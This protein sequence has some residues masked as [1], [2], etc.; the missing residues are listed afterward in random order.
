MRWTKPRTQEL[1][2]RLEAAY[3]EARCALEHAD[4][5]QLVVA[6][7]LSAQC[8]DARVNATTPALFA[9]FPDAAALAGA[10]PDELEALIRPT[11]FFRNKARNLIGLGKALVARHGGRVPSG[12]AELAALPGVGRKTANVV[13]AN[14]FGVPALAVDTHIFRLARRLGLS[15]ASTPEKVETDLCA[16]FPRSSW[17]A[18]HHQ[19]IWHGRRV[20]AA[21]APRCAECSLRDLCP[22]GC[23]VLADP[24][25]GRLL[26]P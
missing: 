11:G 9:R 25:T 19:L 15:E 26:G 10:D 18:L 24:H 14:A 16:R 20:C 23:G 8:T 17:I 6:T 5:F 2:D 21:R 7:I 22:T 12:E 3:P 1:Q 13:L 4:P